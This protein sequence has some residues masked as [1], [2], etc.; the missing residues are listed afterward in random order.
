MCYNYCSDLSKGCFENVFP[1]A[2]EWYEAKTILS[3]FSLCSE[4]LKLM[5]FPNF[6][7]D[8]ML[9]GTAGIPKNIFLFFY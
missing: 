2:L 9:G 6:W 7:A 1:M 8:P 4:S 5:I 3:S